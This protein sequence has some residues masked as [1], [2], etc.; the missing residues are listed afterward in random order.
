MWRSGE[1]KR[2]KPT[3][4]TMGSDTVWPQHAKKQK[5]SCSISKTC[6]PYAYLTKQS[7]K[8]KTDAVDACVLPRR[9]NTN[10]K[11]IRASPAN[12]SQQICCCIAF[13]AC[14]GDSGTCRHQK[15]QLSDNSSRDLL[16]VCCGSC[17]TMVGDRPPSSHH[18]SQRLNVH[19]KTTNYFMVCALQHVHLLS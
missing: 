13:R 15:T 19:E 3:C 4:R 9:I 8:C 14:G 16:G 2:C 17:W 12:D 1:P 10:S 7:P 11:A 18:V 5:M 6:S